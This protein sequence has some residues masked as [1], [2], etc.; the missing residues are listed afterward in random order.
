MRASSVLPKAKSP[1]S[2]VE[3]AP[4]HVSLYTVP[5]SIIKVYIMN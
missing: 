3:A 4:P 2:A 1:P 5:G